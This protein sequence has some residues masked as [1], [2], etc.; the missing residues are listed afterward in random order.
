MRQ[1]GD[2]SSSNKSNGVIAARGASACEVTSDTLPIFGGVV[3]DGDG[4]FVE[5][6][7]GR[8]AK[9]AA[10]AA[11]VDVAVGCQ[12]RMFPCGL[13]HGPVTAYTILHN[14]LLCIA[15]PDYRCAHFP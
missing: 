7:A 15:G 12:R 2:A 1:A 10:A 3:L 6:E 4:V 13:E 5:Y 14:I 9:K 11:V 8:E